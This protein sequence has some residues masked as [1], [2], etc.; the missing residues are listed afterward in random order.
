[1]CEGSVKCSA[2]SATKIKV[3]FS[4]A[5]KGSEYKHP[6]TKTLARKSPDVSMSGNTP[7]GQSLSS[8]LVL[9]V[10]GPYCDLR[11]AALRI[12][13]LSNVNFI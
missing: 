2:L 1:M 10:T 12:T 13:T 6:L 7:E 3:A 11:I 8:L 4:A 5:M 9:Q